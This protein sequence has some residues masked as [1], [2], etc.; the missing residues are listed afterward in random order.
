MENTAFL[1]KE[2]ITEGYYTET[3][4]A[5]K[6]LYVFL[7]LSAFF[8]GAGVVLLFSRVLVTV[9]IGI[10]LLSLF[11]LLLSVSS[12][13]FFFAKEYSDRKAAII[14]MFVSL[15][16]VFTAFIVYTVTALTE[17]ITNFDPNSPEIPQFTIPAYFTA[18]ITAL[19]VIYSVSRLFAFRIKNKDEYENANALL[20][21]HIAFL[22]LEIL[23]SF[24]SEPLSLI[25][26]AINFYVFCDL[27]KDRTYTVG[28]FRHYGN[29]P[30]IRRM[31]EDIPAAEIRT[32]KSAFKNF[33]IRLFSGVRLAVIS[34]AFI[35]LCLIFYPQTEILT[36]LSFSVFFLLPT[37]TV[38]IV[39]AFVKS[40]KKQNSFAI[41]GA[42]T[43]L[44]F[45]LL[46]L[47]GF[48]TIK[49]WNLPL[50][51]YF[52]VLPFGILSFISFAVC[53]KETLNSVFLKTAL[54][55]VITA[56]AVY[57]TVCIAVT[58]RVYDILMQYLLIFIW[59]E[60]FCFLLLGIFKKSSLSAET[61][62]TT[63]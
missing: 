1:K 8:F 24:F 20:T 30:A 47:C 23:F 17:I 56:L 18:I 16:A 3:S 63:R 58:G 42:F 62:V 38:K 19:S 36:P 32:L 51:P 22:A 39:H 13:L 25:V 26:G 37:L 14:I 35:V 11:F 57:F 21:V 28:Y 2:N 40:P 33:T 60:S 52:A 6:T 46:A 43:G 15:G 27:I 31:S 7:V 41:F 45:F 34:A 48:G 55:V 9:I 50:I 61:K 12:V 4:A 29:I 59:A 54:S 10:V 5:A 53:Y 44:E 49:G